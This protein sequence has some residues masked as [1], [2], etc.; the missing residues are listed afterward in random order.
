MSSDLETFVR[1]AR[2]AEDYARFVQAVPYLRF[3]GLSVRKGAEGPV[4]V[5]PADPKLIGNAQ[6]PALH[7][8]VIGALLESAAIIQLIFAAE[9]D[10]IPKI[11]DLSVDYLRSA[12][13]VETFARATITKHGR[14]VANVRAEAWQDDPAK[15]VAAAHAHFL[16]G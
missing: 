14:R 7:G 13:P 3:L 1:E 2:Q 15:P 10:T 16:L 4:C 12:R 5:L 8:G 6:L 9:T 11:I